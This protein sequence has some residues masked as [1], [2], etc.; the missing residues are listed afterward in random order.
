MT[1]RRGVGKVNLCNSVRAGEG[2]LEQGNIE[3]A[4]ESCCHFNA[5]GMIC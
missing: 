3:R 5:F 2:E 1:G 4:K